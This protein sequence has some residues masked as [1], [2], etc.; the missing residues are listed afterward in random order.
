M[1]NNN[2]K[3]RINHRESLFEK[4]LVVTVRIGLYTMVFPIVR[5]LWVHKVT[6]LT[7][8]P[9]TGAAILAFNHQSYF[10]FIGFVAI[11]PRP[12]H[13]LAA[14][15]FYTKETN[16]IWGPIMRAMRQIR[17]D[18]KAQD[19]NAVYAGVYSVLSKGELVGI[20]P[21]G[22]R[23]P[24]DEHM[25]RAFPGVAR[26][27]ATARVPI[28]PIGIR[29]AFTIMSRHDKRPRFKKIL[30]FHAG[31][32]LNPEESSVYTENQY[33]RIAD[34]VMNRISDLSGKPYPYE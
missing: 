33:Q 5:L 31:E 27:A 1:Q 26:F 2:A 17:V 15:K 28:I 9:R 32:A 18:R 4:F 19:K 25:L 16:I 8:I 14:E 3:T 29:G 21:E 10:D 23:A 11:S 30:E 34:M 6:G 20:F 22:T 13:Y 7:N 24:Q 12:I